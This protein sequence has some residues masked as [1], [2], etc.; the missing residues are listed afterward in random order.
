[1]LFKIQHKPN[2]Y[3]HSYKVPIISST[4]YDDINIG[5]KDLALGQERGNI[6]VLVL[7]L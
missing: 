5:T 2:N 1:M 6:E 4:T 3:I 7:E